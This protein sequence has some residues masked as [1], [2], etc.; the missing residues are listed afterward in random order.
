VS[1]LE[2]WLKYGWYQL[3]VEDFAPVLVLAAVWLLV[4][5]ELF[6]FHRARTRRGRG[7]VVAVPVVGWALFGVRQAVNATQMDVAGPHARYPYYWSCILASALAGLAVFLVIVLADRLLAPAGT[8]R[9]PSG[10]VVTSGIV[11]FVLWVAVWIAVCAHEAS[12]PTGVP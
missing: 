7:I 2:W 5:A 6:V 12:L 9:R 4:A 10:G 1:D 11:G 3:G 8:H